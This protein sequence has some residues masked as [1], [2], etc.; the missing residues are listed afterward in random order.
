M[1]IEN[2]AHEIPRLKP[3]DALIPCAIAQGMQCS[4]ADTGI[5]TSC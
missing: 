2:S 1:M 4:T 5:A 3:F